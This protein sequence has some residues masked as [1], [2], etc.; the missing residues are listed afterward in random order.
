MNKRTDCDTREH[1]LET[2]E[3][4]CLERGFTALGLT[5]L[6]KTAGVPKGSFYHHFHSKEAFG[7]ELIQRYYQ[8]CDAENTHNFQQAISGR[9]RVLNWFRRTQELFCSSGMSGNCLPVKLSAE[10]CDLSES[11][12]DALKQGSGRLIQLLSATLREGQQDGSVPNHM[13][14]EELALTLYTLWLGS[15][16]Q[17]KIARDA[18]PLYCA[19]HSAQSLLSSPEQ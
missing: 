18:K 2:G 1:L 14:A 8:R 4:L 16:L 17:A 5:E 12:R 7:V 13:V 11:M 6:L 3:R 10:V 9:E 19:L 15:H